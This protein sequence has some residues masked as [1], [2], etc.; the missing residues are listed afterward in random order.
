MLLFSAA[1]TL[2]TATIIRII[3]FFYFIGGN[4]LVI[5]IHLCMLLLLLLLKMSI[6]LP[7]SCSFTLMNIHFLS[8][9]SHSHLVTL[10]DNVP[11]ILCHRKDFH[12]CNHARW[13]PKDS[14][15]PPDHQENQKFHFSNIVTFYSAVPAEDNT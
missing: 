3:L 8:I 13:N 10:V 12:H 6:F 15:V 4:H 9:A 7:K 2:D 5:C 11:F 14:Y 1:N